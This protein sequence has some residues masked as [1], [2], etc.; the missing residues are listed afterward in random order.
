MNVDD[1]IHSSNSC[2]TGDLEG[3]IN[4]PLAAQ[5]IKAVIMFKTVDNQL[6]VSLRSKGSVDVRVIATRHGGG[7]HK[8]AAGF[9]VA[10]PK[11]DIRTLIVAEVNSSVANTAF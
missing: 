3:L 2:T 6:R 4:L 11:N 7:G 1:E 8:N 9:S 5:S 10:K